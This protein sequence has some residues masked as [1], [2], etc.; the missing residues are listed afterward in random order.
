VIRAGP[1]RERRFAW[2]TGAS[3]ILAA[4]VEREMECSAGETVGEPLGGWFMDSPQKFADDLQRNHG[5]FNPSHLTVG[6]NL[7]IFEP[8]EIVP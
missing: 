8:N 3:F 6:S 1:G 7:Q 2:S 5:T 4:L